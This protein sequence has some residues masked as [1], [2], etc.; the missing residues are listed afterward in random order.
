MNHYSSFALRQPH[1]TQDES[2]YITKFEYKKPTGKDC[3]VGFS[4]GS[5]SCGGKRW[6]KRNMVGKVQGNIAPWSPNKYCNGGGL[7][8]TFILER[9]GKTVIRPLA[10]IISSVE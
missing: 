9:Q 3:C 8:I 7:F 2:L 5:E 1:T 6:L 10:K 4:F